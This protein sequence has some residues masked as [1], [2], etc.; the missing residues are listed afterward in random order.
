MNPAILLFGLVIAAAMAAFVSSLA[1]AGLYYAFD[2]S[3][4]MFQ[5]L[6]D[7]ML[8]SY[9]AARLDLATG[10]WH[11]PAI[12]ACAG[13]V[14]GFAML[15][16]AMTGRKKSTDARFL[17][18]LE[19]RT[20]GLTRT[21]GV[22]VGRIGGSLI[23][24]PGGF[25]QRGSG[26][27]RFL[28]PMLF[29]G[30]KL[31][32]DG[33]DVGGFVIGP[34]RSGK[35]ASLIVPN[36]LLWPDSIV[37]LDMRGETYE[38]TAGYR[39]KFS[40][41][42][43]FSPADENGD[44]ECYNPLD[45]VAIDPDQRDI[46]IN[47]IATAL[48]PTPKGDAY[49][50]SDARALFAG[51]TSWVLEN[52]DIL[53]KDK[54]LG[55][56]LN[57]VE[58]GDQPLRE[59]LGEVANPELRAAWISSFTYTTLA[60][61][62]VMASK[63]F[64]GVYGSLAAAVR[65]F[66]NNRILR[67]TAR[68]TFDIRAMR[69]ENM[70]LYLDFR[71]Q[72]IASIGPIFNV[73]MVQFMDYMSRNMMKRGERRVLVLLDE[74]QNLGKL[75]NAL[76]VATVLG[77]YGIPCWFFVQSLRSIDNVYTREGRQTLVNSAR[78][79]IFLGAQD[80]EDQRYVSQLLGERKE[81]TV[82]KAVS[83]G[84]TLFDRKGATM[85]HKTTMRPLMRPDELGA[86]NETRCV[87]KLRNQQPIFGVRNFYYADGELIR[88]AWLRVRAQ[89]AQSIVGTATP[90]SEL[91]LESNASADGPTLATAGA[92][93]AARCSA[94]A[95]SSTTRNPEVLLEPAPAPHQSEHREGSAITDAPAG[96]PDF[97]SAMKRSAQRRTDAEKSLEKIL[98]FL[99]N[100][101]AKKRAAKKVQKE[102]ASAFSD[103]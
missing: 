78:A 82:D 63:Q 27:R 40:R 21:G 28:K 59:W 38:A 39:S 16:T 89:K 10:D 81:V 102:I 103:R 37:V 32:I 54:N 58:G 12:A 74:F 61:F 46:D 14:A 48:L 6:Q 92:K 77:G 71:I 62:A 88:R 19:A 31:W 98:T 13:A 91:A 36:C 66:K 57:V 22:F 94:A 90:F 30:K 51:V 50:I 70:S 44:T 7:D 15:I 9:R 52:P 8:A 47:S 3:T 1:Y 95:T 33:D 79:Q 41:V 72:Q 100:A 25:T 69:R 85:S 99:E 96:G 97:K 83:T 67:A 55:T 49:W 43:R 24:V 86:M 68:S 34:P 80:P 84:I 101:P 18:P 56:V 42:L 76:N 20:L 87:I 65:P 93:F 29:G 64:D 35:G 4:W 23:K 26:R 53:D 73:L 2:N 45:F 11:R 75:E 17:S 60:R 5:A